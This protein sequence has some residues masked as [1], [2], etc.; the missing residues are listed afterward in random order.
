MHSVALLHAFHK[1]TSLLI[2]QISA[3]FCLV[4][5][6]LFVLSSPTSDTEELEGQN[7]GPETCPT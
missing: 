4:H 6:I 2:R 1:I 5:L 3:G 7:L